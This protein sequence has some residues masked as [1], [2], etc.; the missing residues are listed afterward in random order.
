MM[1]WDGQNMM[2]HRHPNQLTS[3][4]FN[5]DLAAMDIDSIKLY[6]DDSPINRTQFHFLNSIQ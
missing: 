1:C 2:Y 6:S 4:L 3:W 5:G